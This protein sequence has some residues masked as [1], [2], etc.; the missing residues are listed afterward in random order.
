MTDVRL[1]ELI[2]LRDK[3]NMYT[4]FARMMDHPN[5]ESE[6][7][8]KITYT[9]YAIVASERLKEVIAETLHEE[10]EVLTQAFLEA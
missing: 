4:Q 9:D 10:L 2:E 6:L 1:Q 8:L 5:A 3:K 7:L